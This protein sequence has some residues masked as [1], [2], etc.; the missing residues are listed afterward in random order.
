MLF[1]F[2]PL[3]CV[4]NAANIVKKAHVRAV[5]AMIEETVNR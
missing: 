2:L 3:D 1:G 4:Q 5:V